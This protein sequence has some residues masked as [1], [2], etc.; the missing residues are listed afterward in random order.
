MLDECWAL[1]VAAEQSCRPAMATREAAELWC[2][3]TAGNAKSTWWRG[4]VDAGRT[5]AEL[6]LS[7]GL[8]YFE[9]S[10]ADHCDVT[11]PETWGT[12]MP[13]LRHTVSPET[14]QADLASMP[15]PEWRRVVRESMVGRN[16]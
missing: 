16:G 7:E 1:D 15:L 14:I 3:S 4:R 2:L 12:F 10:A 13:A 9:W 6:G 11:D 5:H 8:A